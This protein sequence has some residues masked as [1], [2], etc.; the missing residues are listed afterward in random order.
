MPGAG[1]EVEVGVVATHA[2][3][4]T[5]HEAVVTFRAAQ[6]EALVRY[7]TAQ[8]NPPEANLDPNR[9]TSASNLHEVLKIAQGAVSAE[10]TS[11]IHFR[12][13]VQIAPRSRNNSFR[14]EHPIALRSKNNSFK[15]ER[16]T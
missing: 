4:A 2:V 13:A 9:E 1:A 14:T 15:T 7:A 12:S 16:P 11:P 6:E 5:F 8:D 3:A 10:V